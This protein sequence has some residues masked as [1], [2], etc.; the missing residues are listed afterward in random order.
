MHWNNS[1]SYGRWATGRR[2]L[3]QVVLFSFFFLVLDSSSDDC[4]FILPLHLFL[5]NNWTRLIL[6]VNDMPF[7][8]VS[9]F[10]FSFLLVYTLLYSRPSS[11]LFSFSPNALD[12]FHFNFFKVFY[13]HQPT[14]WVYLFYNTHPSYIFSSFEFYF[15]LVFFFFFFRFV[16]CVCKYR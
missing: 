1:R 11:L 9:H 13:G 6:H 2:L 7:S 8:I 12:G 5:W 14:L 15:I 3:V 4:S 10:P 16:G